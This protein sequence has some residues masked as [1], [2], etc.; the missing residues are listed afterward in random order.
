MHSVTQPSAH[1]DTPPYYNTSQS[2]TQFTTQPNFAHTTPTSAT[3]HTIPNPPTRTHPM[4]TRSQVGTVKPNPHFH[5]HT[6]HTSP[7]SLIP[8]SP[9]IALSDPNWQ[10]AMYDEYN[11][12]IKNS[13]WVLVPKPPNVNVVQSMWL[14]RHKYHVD[15]SL[16][17]YKA[18]LVANGCSQ[19]F[20]VDYDDTF[21]PIVKPATVRTVLS[22]ALSRDWP[23]HQL[24]VKNAFLNGDISETAY[25]YQPPGYAN[26]VGFLS[27]RCDSSLFIY[28]HGYEVAHLLIYVDDILNYF[29]GIFVT[30]DSTC[31]FLSQ[32]KY[33][34]E[35]LDK[36][37]MANCNPTRTPVETESKLGPDGDP[38]SDPTLYRSLAG[39]LQ[40]LTFTRPNISYAV[41]QVCLH[42]HDPQEPHLAAIKRV[43]RYVR[44]ILDFG[45][46]LYASITGSLVAY[47]DADWAGCPTTGRSTSGYCVFLG[48]NLL[49]WSAK[50]QHTLFRSSVEAEY[51]GV[52]NVVSETT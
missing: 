38:I 24:D 39:G 6:S 9:S 46:Q 15:G 34:L 26:R 30:R 19:Q 23:I 52:A 33:V 21:S 2:T 10:D 5:G 17:R 42:M 18:R 20:G 4:V 8:K 51:K 47:T 13:T 31:M 28:Q 37:Y 50:R 1:P 43:L 14:F 40:Y 49:S 22:L 32:K 36:A 48:D 29:L 41:Q 35:L 44:G 12:L 27:S 11:A 3:T 45:L 16:S 25:M 7:I